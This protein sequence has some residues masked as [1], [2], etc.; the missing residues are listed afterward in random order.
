MR[1]SA[2]DRAGERQNRPRRR[3]PVSRVIF[4]LFTTLFI[5]AAMAGA[6]GLAV[7]SKITTS[8]PLSEQTSVLIPQGATSSAIAARLEKRGVISSGQLFKAALLVDRLRGEARP[9]RAG[10][11]A[12]PARASIRQVISILRSGKA[13]VHKITIPEGF[14][15]AQVMERLRANPDL[16]GDIGQPPPEGSL[17]PETYVFR[18]GASRAGII[19][20]MRQAQEKLL[21]RLWPARARDLPFKTRKEAVILASI[22]EKETGKPDERPRVAA[23]FINR[24]K[25]G[26]RLQSDP[27]IIYGITKGKKLGRPIRKSEIAA[28]TPWNTYQIDGLPPTPIANPGRAS[29]EAVLNPAS[30]DDIYFVADGSGGHVFSAT[31]EGHNRNVRKWRALNAVRRAEEKQKQKTAAESAAREPAAA[32]DPAAAASAPAGVET[33]RT[34]KGAIPLPPVAHKQAAARP[35]SAPASARAIPIPRPRPKR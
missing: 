10:E 21:D 7:W 29:I 14:S 6:A 30:T 31:L 5:I 25:K 32:T 22:V 1:R 26:I 9:L 11:Y 3:T 24:L 23:V 35:E 15:V 19:R 12:I 2:K 28:K 8:G 4:S 34:A 27:T 20:R 16:T 13:V 33:A 18:R 17:L